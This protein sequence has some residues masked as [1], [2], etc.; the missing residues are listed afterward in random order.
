MNTILS[1]PSPAVGSTRLPAVAH[2]SRGTYLRFSLASVW[3]I[4]VTLLV[5]FMGWYVEQ[6]RLIQDR[7][8]PWF[9]WLLI[10]WGHALLL[11]LPLVPLAIYTRVPRFRA[12]YRTWA[13]AVAFVWLLGL[14]R[15]FPRNWT[16]GGMFGQIMLCLLAT[17][18]LIRLSRRNG[19][20]L[21][22]SAHS[23]VLGLSLVPIL[24]VPW[25]LWGALGSPFD[26]MLG[27]LTGLSFGLFAGL[28]LDVA[29]MRPF[30]AHTAGT[31]W[32]ILFCSCAGGV[33]LLILAAGFGFG[34]TQLLLQICLPPLGV[35]AMALAHVATPGPDAAPRSSLPMAALIGG[36]T[37]APLMFI[38]PAELLLL[39]P[40]VWAF[41]AAGAGLVLACVL[42]V[43]LWAARHRASLLSRMLTHGS[44]VATS[45]G[46]LLLHGFAGQPGFYGDRL[47]VILR[48]QAE[49]R[50]AAEIPNREARLHAAYT[51]LTRHAEQSQANLRA[52]LDRL[53]VKYTTY[54][55]VNAL[56]VEGGLPLRAYLEQQPEVD[57]VLSSP[58]L[59][60]LPGLPL[61]ERGDAPAP[62]QPQWNITMIGVDR[63]WKELH[64]TGTGIVVGQTDS[65]VHRDHPALR[66]GYRGRGDQDDYNWLDPW[67]GTGSPTDTAGHGTHTLGVA[68]GR[69]GIGVAP[70]AEWIACTPARNL[71]NPARY[72]DCLQFLLAPY[73][74]QGDPFR[75]GD[76]ARAAHVL[77]NSWVCPPLEGCDPSALLPAVRALRAA[78]I[79]VVAAA[80]NNGPRCSSVSNPPAVYDEVFTVGEVDPAGNVTAASS[81]GPVTVDGSGRVKP[82]I[83]APGADVLSSLPGS[84]YGRHGGTSIA[85]PHVTGVVA[86]MWSAQPRLIGNIERTEQILATTARPYT[87][88]RVGC[89]GDVSGVPNNAAGYGVVDAYAAV[90]AALAERS[91]A[92]GPEVRMCSE[93]LVF[94][95][96]SHV[97]TRMIDTVLDTGI[98][99]EWHERRGRV[100]W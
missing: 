89:F 43:G 19:E 75:V 77:N 84:T 21:E 49:V 96:A 99:S 45:C 83:L 39:E 15:V 58:R 79:F 16:Q 60:P 36:A 27:I 93:L 26:T 90:K 69:N 28:L 80:S 94:E 61:A 25:L 53:G 85:G 40:P 37:A 48:D 65:G 78:G 4:I 38:D 32:D 9:G 81:R 66:D 74:Q 59:R 67:N 7:P 41:K 30:V 31:G 52:K 98:Q 34:G 46:A 73:P 63:V 18:I 11:A 95:P 57:R 55:L 23:V 91:C 1:P 76:A 82:D 56:E 88:E 71:G 8:L 3:T 54:Y 20:R 64:V 6:V 33:A 2:P 100:P 51:M 42:S 24:A 50:S 35:A 13:L 12:I 5:P 70:G 29:L 68:V 17:W 22:F 72:L 10:S 14:V 62:T 92:L 86:L 97:P 87:G 47:F 44:L